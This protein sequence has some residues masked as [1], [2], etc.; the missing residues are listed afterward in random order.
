MAIKI[1]VAYYINVG[2][3]KLLAFAQFSLNRIRLRCAKLAVFDV[4]FVPL[5]L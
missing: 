3:P 2:Q 5:K 1:K 4:P